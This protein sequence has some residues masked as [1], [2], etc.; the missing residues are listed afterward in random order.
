MSDYDFTWN[1]RISLPQLKWTWRHD[2][3]P[4]LANQG[5]RGMVHEGRC[6]ET[7][8]TWGSQGENGKTWEE[9]SDR[10]WRES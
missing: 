10:F 4:R 6:L 1:Y 5:E 9:S 3:V 7:R 8:G 2:S